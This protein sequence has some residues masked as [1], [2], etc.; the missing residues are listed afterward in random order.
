MEAVDHGL[1]SVGTDVPRNDFDEVIYVPA[2]RAS[3]CAKH[4]LGHNELDS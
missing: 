2:V 1:G 4:K 3:E